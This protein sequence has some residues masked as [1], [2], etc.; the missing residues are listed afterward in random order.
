MSKRA[1]EEM[2]VKYKLLG[3]TNELRGELVKASQGDPQ[4]AVRWGAAMTV[5]SAPSSSLC[6][7]A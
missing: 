5:A 6:L 7:N 4:A 3:C 2:V 1:S